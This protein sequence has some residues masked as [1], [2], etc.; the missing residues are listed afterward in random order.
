MPY[1]RILIVTS[2]TGEKIAKPENQLTLED[3]QDAKRLKRG[4][5]SLAAFSRPA[6]QMYTGMQHL[7]L[8]EGVGLLRQKLGQS[9]VDVA[10]LS[11]GYGLISGGKTIV[12]Y[13]VTFNDMNKEEID[14]WASHLH[15]HQALEKLLLQGQNCV[16]APYDLVFFLLGENYLRAAGLPLKIPPSQTLIFLAARK[17]VKTIEELVAK[18]FILPLSN[19]EAK[20]YR[21][22]LVGLKGF[23]FKQFAIAATEQPELLNSVCENPAIFEQVISREIQLEMPIELPEVIKK[24]QAKPRAISF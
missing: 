24:K 4:E 8:M 22:G 3:F 16:H 23:L 13:E 1:P 17:S 5:K 12:P 9:V 7:R 21:Y 11:A 10:I 18:T 15:I 2:C 19:A 20:Q 14:N 6:E